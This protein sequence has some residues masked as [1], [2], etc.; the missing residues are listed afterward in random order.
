MP[1]L[2]TLTIEVVAETKSATSNINKLAKSMEALASAAPSGGA[3]DSLTSSLRNLADAAMGIGGAGSDFVILAQGIKKVA[4]AAENASKAAT[5]VQ[6]LTAV[7]Q[8]VSNAA[9]AVDMSAMERVAKSSLMLGEAGRS[10]GA[11]SRG[12]NSVGTS[13]LEVEVTAG[14]FEKFIYGINEASKAIDLSAL[15]PIVNFSKTI[16]AAATGLARFASALEK[17][18][19]FGTDSE[20]VGQVLNTI[21]AVIGRLV[22]HA[23][24]LASLAVTLTNVTSALKTINRAGDVGAQ[25]QRV[26]KSMHRASGAVSEFAKKLLMLPLE[27]LKNKIIGL[28]KPLQNL[29]HSFARIA[30]YRALRSAIKAITQGFSEGIKHLYQWSELTGNSFKQSMDSLATSAHYLRDSLGAMASPLID[31]LA[32]AV[33]ILVDKFVSLINIVNQFI[34]TFTGKDTWRRAVRTATEYDDGIKD[35]TDSTKKATEAQKK[36]NKAL[37]DFDELN[38]ITTST[39][40]GS[41]PTGSN[42]NN[43][44]GIDSTHFVEEPIENW[45]QDIKKAIEKGDWGGAGT[46]LANKLNGMLSKWKAQE[47]GEK[48]GTKFQK[49]INF[50]LAFMRTFKWDQLGI[51]SAKFINGILSKVK[52][53]DLGKAIVAKFNASIKFLSGFTK[54][55]NWK[56]AGEW[57]ADVLV[58]AF[59]GINWSTLGELMKELAGGLLDMLKAGIKKLWDSKKQILKSFGDF[60]SN[61]GWDGLKNIV[62]LALIISGFKLLFSAVFGSQGL[63]NSVKDSISTMFSGAGLYNGL[64]F[65]CAIGLVWAST[66]IAKNI[67][68]YGWEKGIKKSIGV[69]TP[70]LTAKLVLDD[71]DFL[72]QIDKAW[73]VLQKLAHALGFETPETT[74]T[75]GT[76]KGKKTTEIDVTLTKNA[77]QTMDKIHEMDVALQFINSTFKPKFTTQGYDD[78]KKKVDALNKQLQNTG[79]AWKITVTADLRLKPAKNGSYYTIEPAMA[80]GGY[81]QGSLFVAG[82]VPGQAEM[83]GNIHGKT[84]VASGKE[85]T[86]IADAVYDTGQTEAELLRQQNGLLRQILQKSGSVTLAP[87]AAAG[88]WVAQSQAAY[89][90]ATG[91]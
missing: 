47:F 85:I 46:L 23:P 89:A 7:F 78:T 57:L 28:I 39:T 76:G 69:V 84:G 73:Q 17:L 34:A 53:K 50:Y 72:D 42:S 13:M 82:E 62:E 38:L 55:F 70:T 56:K 36:L 44:T 10:L 9:S 64:L 48:I 88:K 26:E 24:E 77:S 67:S 54:S 25:I 37:Q 91:G 90:R 35:A 8:E 86:G 18:A 33:E 29:V 12:I 83:V 68:E 14:R 41:T 65:T 51:K 32:P 61:L 43:D 79:K 60:F 22:A 4:D 5:S 87:T 31:A 1:A 19:K 3:I 20:K 11:F 71:K 2:D 58:G 45:I 6:Q 75:G 59:T 63:I 52:A 49:A 27:R 40:K 80:E 15:Q 74:K 81:P 30:M 16:G 21:D 66:G